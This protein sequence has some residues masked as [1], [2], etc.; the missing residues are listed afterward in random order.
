VAGGFVRA[1]GDVVRVAADAQ[2]C[3]HGGA[4]YRIVRGSTS[5]HIARDSSGDLYGSGSGRS[6]GKE[7][8]SDCEHPSLIRHEEKA[9]RVNL[10]GTR[11]AAMVAEVGGY[12]VL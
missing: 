2:R 4:G 8:G 3:G 11:A 7:S 10:G 6:T 12:L 5:Q 9:V 1:E